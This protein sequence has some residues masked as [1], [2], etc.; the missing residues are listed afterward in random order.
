MFNLEGA[1]NLTE[2]SE[3]ENERKKN[4]WSSYKKDN[5]VKKII[6]DR[7]TKAIMNMIS[8]NNLLDG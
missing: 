7:Q 2:F 1:Y 4:S 6:S 5:S 3:S 8:G